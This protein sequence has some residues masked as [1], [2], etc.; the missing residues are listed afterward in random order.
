VGIQLA[1]LEALARAGFTGRDIVHSATD[2]A[3]DFWGM[4]ALGRLEPGKDASFLV[5]AED[6]HLTPAVLAAPS[7]VVMKGVTVAGV[8]P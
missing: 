4:D 5:L 3:A 6:P 7:S 8:L 1:E 2:R